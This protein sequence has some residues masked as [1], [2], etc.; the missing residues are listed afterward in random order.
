M[1]TSHIPI[2]FGIDAR[3][4]GEDAAQYTLD[5][6]AKS[7]ELRGV[8]PRRVS[9]GVLLQRK[10]PP[11]DG[12]K[13]VPSHEPLFGKRAASIWWQLRTVCGF[14]RPCYAHGAPILAG[15]RWSRSA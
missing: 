12:H 6:S 11:L 14:W 4:A 15:R 9:A 13:F 1:R 10:K 7:P 8:R 5:F 2:V 3:P